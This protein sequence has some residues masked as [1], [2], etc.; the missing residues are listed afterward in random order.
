MTATRL[1]ALA[2]PNG[3]A[4][5][6]A[7]GELF[8]RIAAVHAVQSAQKMGGLLSP[9]QYGIGVRAGCEHI[10]HCMQHSLSH[11]SAGTP[12]AA[13]KVDITNAFNTCQRPR[14][15]TALLAEPSLKDTLGVLTAHNTHPH[16]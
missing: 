13:V 14:L 6:I 4:R 12:L 5:P 10:V 3:K 9:H 7:M 1:I 16:R 2:K 15:L 11:L 8:Y